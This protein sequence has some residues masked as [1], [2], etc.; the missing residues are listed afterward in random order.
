LDEPDLAPIRGARV[1]LVDD[2][3]LNL[4]VAGE[5]L[6]QAKLYVDVAHDGSEAVDKVLSGQY[7]CVL[8]DVQMPVMDGYTATEKIREI[9]EYRELPIIAMTANA[10]PQ[11][12]ARGTE[13]GM[14]DYV[15][16]PIEPDLLHRTLLRWI[17]HGDR[18]YEEE[19]SGGEVATRVEL[20]EALPGVQIGTGLARLG[21]N[22]GLYLDLL[23]GLC[24]D[25]ADCAGR[26]R[27]RLGAGDPE[28]AR[29]LAHKLRGIANNL[30]AV[31]LG[32][33][34]ETIEISLKAG[35]TVTEDALSDLDSAIALTLEAQ[36]S[37]APLAETKSVAAEMDAGERQG[38]LDQL[39]QAITDNNPEALDI[40]DKLLVGTQEGDSD[41]NVL[42]AAR[43]ALDSYDFAGALEQLGHLTSQA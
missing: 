40:A 25:Y 17:A 14:N 13:A 15:P 19:E 42:S 2:S 20:P 29:Q 41:F 36:A 24:A 7:E 3:E 1:L 10:M 5:L 37:L 23:K 8:M 4:Q 43:D 9:N 11:D 34:A 33:C 30:G 21:G 35:D 27:D 12:R 32:T 6:R 18:D 39:L 26:L 22:V 38:L 28:G 31:E 16:K